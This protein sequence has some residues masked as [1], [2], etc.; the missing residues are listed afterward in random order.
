[1]IHLIRKFSIACGVSKSSFI[2]ERRPNLGL[3]LGA[4]G[5]AELWNFLA[6][7]QLWIF[8]VGHEPFNAVI[9]MILRRL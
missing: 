9:Q 4:I 5:Q 6:L 8:E 7:D 3:E 1:M 2:H